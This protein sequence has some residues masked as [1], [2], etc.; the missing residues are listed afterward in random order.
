MTATVIDLP[1]VTDPGGYLAARDHLE[2][3]LARM[4]ARAL[5]A[6]E[7]AERRLIALSVAHGISI[8]AERCRWVPHAP[9]EETT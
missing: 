6:E 5:A 4:T 2:R 9:G 7:L 1:P 3:E 8:E